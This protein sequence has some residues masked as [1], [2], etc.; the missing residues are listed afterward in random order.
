MLLKKY[1]FLW[2]EIFVA[3]TIVEILLSF[4]T[5]IMKINPTKLETYEIAKKNSE[6]CHFLQ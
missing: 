5:K 3:L 2:Q 1:C 6:F 4:N